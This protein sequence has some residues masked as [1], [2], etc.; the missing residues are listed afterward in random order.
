MKY[1]SEGLFVL[2]YMLAVADGTLQ[3]KGTYPSSP[4]RTGFLLYC[5]Q[6]PLIVI[7][8]TC[9]VVGAIIGALS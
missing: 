3:D 7:G 1:I 8:A 4:G 9:G 2:A 6:H 5:K